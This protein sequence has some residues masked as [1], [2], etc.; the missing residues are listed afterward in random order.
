[1]DLTQTR[2]L[3]TVLVD[4]LF[5]LLLL[6]K[7]VNFYYKKLFLHPNTLKYLKKMPIDTIEHKNCLGYLK[8]VNSSNINLIY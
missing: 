7:I 5:A 2:I 8:A 1:M 6:K 4:K 3:S